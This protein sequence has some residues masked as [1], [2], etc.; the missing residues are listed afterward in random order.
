MK[1]SNKLP[2]TM[3][4]FRSSLAGEILAMSIYI[5]NKAWFKAKYRIEGD[6]YISFG[7]KSRIDNLLQK[8]IQNRM[9]L[10]E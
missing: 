7:H 6:G 9:R 1:P 5:S 4:Y 10:V 2:V 3:Q 8:D